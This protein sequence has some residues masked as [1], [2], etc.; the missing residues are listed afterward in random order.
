MIIYLLKK[1]LNLILFISLL[2]IGSILYKK[3]SSDIIYNTT[4]DLEILTLK[5]KNPSFNYLFREFKKLVKQQNNNFKKEFFYQW[6][7]LVKL[8][9][10]KISKQN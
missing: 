9:E 2:I 5:E 3:G 4:R 8:I 6:I 1:I 10:K 7:T